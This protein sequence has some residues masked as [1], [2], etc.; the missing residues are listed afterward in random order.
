MLRLDNAPFNVSRRTENFRVARAIRTKRICAGEIY[1][2]GLAERMNGTLFSGALTALLA[3]GLERCLWRYAVIYQTVL[4]N[5]KYSSLTRSSPHLLMLGVKP[6]VFHFQE[7]G[8]ETWL[9]SRVDQQPAHDGKFDPLGGQV[10]FV[11]YPTSQQDF[12][13]LMSRSLLPP[14]ILSLAHCPCSTR[15]SVEL[16]YEAQSR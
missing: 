11:G 6:D 16:H 1:L 12:L 4:Q 8:C 15:S 5:I 14:I 3:S 9:H 13:V 10:I 7:F 2:L